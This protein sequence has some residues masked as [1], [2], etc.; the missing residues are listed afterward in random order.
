M[1]TIDQLKPFYQVII[2]EVENSFDLNSLVLAFR[3][4]IDEKLE[5]SPYYIEIKSVIEQDD[6]IYVTHLLH[7]F[8]PSWY[9]E[10]TV[11]KNSIIRNIENIENDLLILYHADNYLFVYSQCATVLNIIDIAIE[12]LIESNGFKFKQLKA[13]KMQTIL[14]S[15]NIQYRTLAISNIFNAG[16][17]APESK[18]YYSKNAKHC[19]SPSFDTG[20]GFNYC[21]GTFQDEENK[22]HPFGISS[23]KSKIWRTWVDDIDQFIENCDELVEMINNNSNSNN[24]Q[25]L[26]EPTNPPNMSSTNVL[27][28][29]MDY[30]IQQKG[31]VFLEK[32]N[33]VLNWTCY[34]NENHNNQVIFDVIDN[35]THHIVVIDF[36]YEEADEVF[37]FSYNNIDNSIKVLIWNEIDDNEKKRRVDL[38]DYLNKQRNFTLLLNNGNAYRDNAFWKDNRFKST[39][40]KTKTLINWN[41]VDITKEDEIPAEPAKINILQKL[42]NYAISDLNCIIGINDNGSSEIADLIVITDE[43]IILIHAKFSI[44]ARPTL[45]V[46]NIQVVISQALKNLRYFIS[47]NYTDDKLLRLFQKKFYPNSISHGDFKN[48][49]INS[50]NDYNKKKEC[51]I[52]QPG[53][54][55]RKL[56]RSPANKIHILLNYIDSVCTS[57]GIEF[58]FYGN[59]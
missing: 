39:F 43:K 33:P 34:L 15:Y 13:Q 56:M 28:F 25:L 47:E 48:E 37:L 38:I 8:F 9:S 31:M 30:N 21:L 20:F 26:V 19:L 12:K 58:S 2:F 57:N 10:K 6:L 44:T 53:I 5:N 18:A 55:K 52:V 59:D 22:F 24:L 45:R 27:Q 36:I 23:K 42:Q 46:D 32:D 51:W 16:G 1:I 54:S 14:N 49:I 50:L 17:T 40:N 7:K 3:T 11:S 4:S 29:Y 35:S 41:N